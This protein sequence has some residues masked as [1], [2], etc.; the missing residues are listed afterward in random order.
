MPIISQFYGIVIRMFFN[1]A[2]KHFLEH[3]HVQ[4]G[5]FDAT[6]SIKDVKLIEGKLPPKQ[7][8]LVVAWIEI[9]KDELLALWNVAQT[10]GEF[11]KIDPLK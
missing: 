6:Y 7:Q 4:Y 5:E 8:K 10:N 1:D 3:I 9:H 11:F 2:E